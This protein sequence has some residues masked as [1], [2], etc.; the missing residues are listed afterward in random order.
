MLVD[1]DQIKALAESIV[2]PL[3]VGATQEQEEG[4]AQVVTN[5]QPFLTT[6]LGYHVAE[7]EIQ[8][9]KVNTG[10]LHAAPAPVVTPTDGGVTLYNTQLKADVNNKSLDQETEGKGFIQ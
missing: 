5:M 4:L 6:V 7:T 1:A 8:G 3:P 2:P 9:L 10:N